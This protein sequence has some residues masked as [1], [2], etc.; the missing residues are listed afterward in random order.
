MISQTRL[1]RRSN[2]R[3]GVT[4]EPT[5]LDEI[6]DL[7]GD[8]DLSVRANKALDTL[9]ARFAELKFLD[10]SDQDLNSQ[11]GVV[12][13]VQPAGLRTDRPQT[14]EWATNVDRE[15]LLIFEP[16][17]G[18]VTS[19]ES[20]SQGVANW[21]RSVPG[22]EWNLTEKIDFKNDGLLTLDWTHQRLG[23]KDESTEIS[24]SHH[25]VEESKD[26][27]EYQFQ[28]INTRNGPNLLGN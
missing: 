14:E 4:P 18:K 5:T 17:T 3:L 15:H 23:I 12:A 22:L 13:L 25:L 24:W 9:E 10:N 11:E 1:A 8:Q 19:F 6:A 2:N 20:R 21:I 16:D 26:Q 27:F 7:A 28:Q